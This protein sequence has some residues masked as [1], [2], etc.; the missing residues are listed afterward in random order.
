MLLKT[1]YQYSLE[2]CEC[3]HTVRHFNCE[4][5]EVTVKYCKVKGVLHNTLNPAVI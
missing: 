2:A 3:T 4:A 1:C 5:T